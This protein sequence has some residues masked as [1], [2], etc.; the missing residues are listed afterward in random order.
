MKRLDKDV[1]LAD[2]DIE[3]WKNA[4]KDINIIPTTI[5]AI[6]HLFNFSFIFSPLT[7]YTGIYSL[8][9]FV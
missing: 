6:C 9:I 2:D 5:I 1:V 4:P 3:A 8:Y 7:K